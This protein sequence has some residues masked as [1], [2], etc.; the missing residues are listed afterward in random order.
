VTKKPPTE[1]DGFA[2]QVNRASERV[3]EGR[4]QQQVIDA[5]ADLTTTA[6][7]ELKRSLKTLPVQER[8]RLALR[9]YDIAVRHAMQRAPEDTEA[10]RKAMQVKFDKML[11]EVLGG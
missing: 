3:S 10:D 9:L 11:E 1:G 5:L 2:A 8:H 4:H 6:I 7:S